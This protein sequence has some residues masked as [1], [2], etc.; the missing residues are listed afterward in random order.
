MQPFRIVVALAALMSLCSRVH[1]ADVPVTYSVDFRAYKMNVAQGAPLTFALYSDNAC[2]SLLSS[3]VVTAGAPIRQDKILVQA[4]KDQQPRPTKEM[5][6]HTTLNVSTPADP[7]FLKVTGTGIVPIGTACQAQAA[8]A[9]DATPTFIVRNANAV[10]LGQT[11]TATA[12]CGGSSCVLNFTRTLGTS[13]NVDCSVTETTGG[14]TSVT[15]QGF[16]QEYFYGNP[17]CTGQVLIE[18]PGIYSPSN[19]PAS[20]PDVRNVKNKG[21][22]GI[23]LWSESPMSAYTSMPVYRF[24]GPCVAAGTK[25]VIAPQEDNPA[26]LNVPPFTVGP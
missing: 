6:L 16:S 11:S 22:T 3:Q 8:H 26:L 12:G 7:V 24:I 20:P 15:C 23:I 1:A 5:R 19:L 10:V 21:G 25:L 18:W 9:A 17:S 13:I 4:V 14:S 2:T